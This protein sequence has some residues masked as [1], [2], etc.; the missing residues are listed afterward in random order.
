MDELVLV[1]GSRRWSSWS[2]RPYVAARM[3]GATPRLV[4][5]ALR[6]PEARAD[7][8]KWSPSGKVPCLIHGAVVV[9]DSLAICEYLAELFP[10]AGL[11][12]EDR[13]A[14]A[15]ARAVSAEMHS[16]FPVLRQTCSMEL[17]ATTPL[18]DIPADLAAE[19]ERLDAIWTDCR[20]RF[21]A[22][23]PFLF[24]R[25]SVADA[26]FAPVATRCATYA[27]PLGEGA[28]AYRDTLLALPALAEWR[29]GACP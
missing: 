21:G 26:M 6:R 10:A 20:A 11:W 12:P 17:C 15:V 23:G 14:R 7:I 8:L 29:Q 16:G 3:A 28:A 19:L 4:E 25:F 18:A 27:L 5:I 22:G 2:L 13:A 1:I 24:G 9:W